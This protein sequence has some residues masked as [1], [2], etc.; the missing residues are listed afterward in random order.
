MIAKSQI[1]TFNLQE[2]ITI[3]PLT[4]ED[5]PGLEWDGAY[6]AH[7]SVFRQTFE[8]TRQGQRVMLIAVAG[9]TIVGQ[10]FIQLVSSELEYANGVDRGYLYALRVRPGWQGQGLGTR[11]IAAAETELR[12]RGFTTAVIAVGK[13]NIDARRLY[14]RLGYHAFADDPGV[15]YFTDVNGAQ[16]T[17]EEPCWVMEK[18]IRDG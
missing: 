2:R 8:Q 10:A 3:R 5:L 7:R 11:L 17:M 6:T 14:E 12:S 9:E 18:V 16:Q 13:E 4:A 1:P 15:W